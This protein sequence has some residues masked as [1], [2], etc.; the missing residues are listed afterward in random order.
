M[1]NEKRTSDNDEPIDELKQVI[2]LFLF[3]VNQ[4]IF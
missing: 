4:D 2:I 1:E 3:A